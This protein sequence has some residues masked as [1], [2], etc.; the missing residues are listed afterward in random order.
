MTHLFMLACSSIST[1]YYQTVII[2]ILSQSLSDNL[3]RFC[4]L[5]AFVRPVVLLTSPAPATRAPQ[6]SRFRSCSGSWSPP[7]TP[8]RPISPRRFLTK[9]K[10]WRVAAHSPSS[11]QAS[12]APFPSSGSL[13]SLYA[14]VPTMS[15]VLAAYAMSGA[16]SLIVFLP[17]LMT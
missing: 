10:A 8:D 12:S 6:H 5:R 15:L 13:K 9:E 1:M 16:S 7:Y 11:L 3:S 2:N 17:T 14:Y 4:V